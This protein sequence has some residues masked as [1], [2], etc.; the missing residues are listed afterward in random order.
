[1]KRL[2]F[3]IC[4]LLAL[5]GNN[6]CDMILEMP[7]VTGTVDL[8]AVFS[9]SRDAQGML[10]AAYHQAL[11]HGLP[12]GWGSLHGTMATLNGELTRGYSWHSVYTMVISGPNTAGQASNNANAV[13]SEIFS[14][15]WLIIRRCYLVIDNIEKVQ[16][17]SDRM[18]EFI[19][20]EAYGLI[21]YRYMGM[22]YRFGGL[23]IVRGA[24]AM[25]DDL[26]A[27]R[28]SLENTLEF[29]LEIM[30]EAIS[31]LP[32]SWIDIEPGLS[33]QWFG[34]LTKG[35]VL[36]MKAR[37]LT[38]AA[39]PLFNSATP[40]Y[41]E[42]GMSYPDENADLVW[43]GGYSEQRYRD[44]IRA[45]E[46]VLNWA[47]RNGAYLI[48]TAGEGNRNTFEDA[49]RDYGRAHSELYNPEVLLAYKTANTQ[50][51]ANN[52]NMGFNFSN[53]VDVGEKAQ[54]GMTTNFLRLYRDRDG[55]DIDWPRVGEAAPRPISDFRENIEKIEPRF[56]V[57]MCV[58]G[59][60]SLANPGLPNWNE[61]MQYLASYTT[62]ASVMESM[63]RAQ[64]GRAVGSPTK[65]FYGAGTRVWF[66]LPL[67]RLAE[68]YI[69]LA[70][71]YNELGD[72]T[73][74]LK[75]LNIIRNRA[76]LP[77]LTVTDKAQIRN[78]IQ[79]ENSLEFFFE[80]HRY[81][82]MK[83]WKHPEIGTT[84][85]GGPKTEISFYRTGSLQF[86]DNLISYWDA[87]SYTAYWHPKWF[88]EGFL[89]S[90]INKGIIVQNPGY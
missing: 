90:E 8:D 13:G 41:R 61:S 80:N 9:N 47:S 14:N 87:T 24:Y 45:H 6:S 11:R 20:G 69:N 56:R 74:A 35:A 22:F 33:D 3:I 64:E 66:E 27:P 63:A 76:G 70:E 4:I 81:F 84:I 21:S 44:A 62:N 15:N 75:Y 82:D 55:G 5:V 50:T 19:R 54:I 29:I 86:W 40:F 2:F 88:L 32:D 18:K 72:V 59:A 73:N 57:D 34:R 83:H 10:F 39:R 68:N 23:P 89:Q 85:L 36:A 46:E 48:F 30:D 78:E 42:Y 53:Y 17:M 26:A 79:R 12:E 25:N 51:V 28:E 77:S 49:V 67:F 1:M 37:L 60:F 31:R 65:F 38:F 16:D 58:P 7:E 52:M 43:F 71:A